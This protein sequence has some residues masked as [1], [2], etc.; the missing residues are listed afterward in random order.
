M[1]SRYT[2][3]IVG[4]GS[5]GHAH[6]EGY[7]KLDRIEVIAVAD[8]IEAARHQYVEEY[9]ISHEFTTVEEMMDAVKPGGMVLFETYNMDYLNYSQFNK[10]YL[11]KTNELLEVFKDFKIIRYQSFDNGKEAYSS[12]IAQRPF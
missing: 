9:H 1:P 7:Q 11:L 5:I 8:P 2:A 10:N 3:A 12:I 4:C 6:M